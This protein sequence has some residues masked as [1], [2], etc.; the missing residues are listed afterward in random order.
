MFDQI[1][2]YF[3]KKPTSNWTKQEK[4]ALLR[5]VY[6]IYN[7]DK[8]F[9]E[10]EEE[11]FTRQLNEMGLNWRDDI[12]KIQLEEATSLLKNDPKK[13]KIAYGYLAHAVLAD[14]TIAQGELDFLKNLS[15]KF[16]FS[17]SEIEALI[18]EDRDK[19]IKKLK[20]PKDLEK[21]LLDLIEKAD[22]SK[23]QPPSLHPNTITISEALSI[24]HQNAAR[25]KSNWDRSELLTLMK[26][27]FDIYT[28]DHFI[29]VEQREFQKL[30]SEFQLSDSEVATTD[31]KVGLESFQKQ[32]GGFDLVHYLV[33]H[34]I[35]FDNRYTSEEKV[36]LNDY[37]EKYGL[38]L[39]TIE[40]H[41]DSLKKIPF[42]KDHLV[43][44]INKCLE[45]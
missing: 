35:M 9:S 7:S 13:L 26:L 25:F 4:T 33:A 22:L 5:L 23:Y 2:E 19:E 21:N 42:K 10:K 32:H 15:G 20:N 31:L 44:L 27:I 28:A 14:G 6:E 17:I 11:D 8:D 29:E 37:S 12:S 45:K 16:G 43:D 3:K 1:L 36:L 38:S 24:F 40:S 18:Y 30:L 34:A 39:Q 41:I